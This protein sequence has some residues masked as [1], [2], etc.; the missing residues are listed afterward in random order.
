MEG[1]TAQGSNWDWDYGAPVACP[2]SDIDEVFLDYSGPGWDPVTGLGS[3]DATALVTNWDEVQQG[4]K[5]S[6]QRVTTMQPRSGCVAPVVRKNSARGFQRNV[7]LLHPD[8]T[9]TANPSNCAINW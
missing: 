4:I 8:R 9:A 5:F 2:A 1:I 6:D 3:L 7:T